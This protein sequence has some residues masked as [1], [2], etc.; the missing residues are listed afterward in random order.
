MGYKDLP[1][2]PGRACSSAAIAASLDGNSSTPLG[3][4]ANLFSNT[5]HIQVHP[6]FTK[7]EAMHS[8]RIRIKPI[9]LSFVATSVVLVISVRMFGG[10]KPAQPKQASFQVRNEF[11]VQVPKGAKT[12]RMWFSVPQEDA[13]SVIREFSVAA[14]FPVHYYRDDWGN[15]V[16]YAEVNAP[17]EGPITIREGFGLTRTETRND[18]DPTRTRPLTDQE[19]AALFAYLQPSSHVAIQ[20]CS[21]TD[22]GHQSVARRPL[23][24]YF[25]LGNR[26]ISAI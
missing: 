17:A 6:L 3:R 20:G 1:Q 24:L 10:S 16:G 2:L 26:R 12:V 11:K 23:P 7:K 19:R 8:Q 13:V 25:L 9:F 5:T 15:R 14:D 22:H 4:C 18:I 21:A